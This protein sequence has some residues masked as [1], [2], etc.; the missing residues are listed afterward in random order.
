[1]RFNGIPRDMKLLRDLSIVVSLAQKKEQLR[2]TRGQL[3][4][5][6]HNFV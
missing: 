3:G 4:E 2:F 5:A 1:M 6:G